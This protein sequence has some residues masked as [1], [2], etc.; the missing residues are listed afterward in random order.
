MLYNSPTIPVFIEN[1]LDPMYRSVL[2]LILFSPVL[3]EYNDHLKHLDGYYGANPYCY[4]RSS[5]FYSI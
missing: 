1:L 5:Y 4:L 2:S 3:L